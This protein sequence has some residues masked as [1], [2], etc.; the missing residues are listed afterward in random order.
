MSES[1]KFGYD[2]YFTLPSSLLSKS[3][4]CPSAIFLIKIK[5]DNYYKKIFK[6]FYGVLLKN[7]LRLG[8]IPIEFYQ[9]NWINL[10][11]IS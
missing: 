1:K 6:L 3:T 9:N 11:S 7:D 2:N 4:Y 8:P 5:I 10:N